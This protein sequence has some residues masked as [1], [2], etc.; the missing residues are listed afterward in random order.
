MSDQLWTLRVVS[1][2]AAKK[3]V[4]PGRRS[5]LLAI[6]W[7][8]LLVPSLTQS[9]DLQGIEGGVPRKL[10][11]WQFPHGEAGFFFFAAGKDT[12]GEQDDVAQYEMIT[13]CV[14]WDEAFELLYQMDD[15]RRPHLIFANGHQ[16]SV[17]HDGENEFPVSIRFVIHQG[18]FKSRVLTPDPQG[19]LAKSD[20]SVRAGDF[21]QIC[22]ADP[23]LEHDQQS[24]VVIQCDQRM[25]YGVSRS[26]VAHDFF[27][28]P[29]MHFVVRGD[30]DLIQLMGGFCTN[31]KSPMQASFVGLAFQIPDGF[32]DRVSRGGLAT[33]RDWDESLR[34]IRQKVLADRKSTPNLTVE[35]EDVI[36]LSQGDFESQAEAFRR[37]VALTQKSNDLVDRHLCSGDAVILDPVARG[38]YLEQLAWDKGTRTSFLLKFSVML[39]AFQERE[40]LFSV[41]ANAASL[42]LGANPLSLGS[43]ELFF[44]GNGRPEIRAA[45]AA[46]WE[47]PTT[48]GEIDSVAQLLASAKLRQTRGD[49]M[50]VLILLGAG[51][52]IPEQQLA[53][54]CQTN[55]IDASTPLRRRKLA[56]LMKTPSGRQLLLRKLAD[57]SLPDAVQALAK[58]I[59]GT[60]VDATKQLKRFDMIGEA[61]LQ[62]LEAAL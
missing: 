53:T 11:K 52:R 2:N 42:G 6:V 14:L 34:Q 45:L 25:L 17:V 27:G 32:L 13:Q 33:A 29:M 35:A 44:D 22:N 50:D 51:D 62:R 19:V 58:S 7:A 59:I 12:A 57:G 18:V 30:D 31:L 1:Q 43:L 9:Q 54:W 15:L 36:R 10:D 3:H 40:M 61:E 28:H 20:F 55:L 5:V 23:R 60:H 26:A 4:L 47:L 24:S 38:F 56:Y 46:H 48:P 21:L 16:H 8:A 49:A 37:C 39:R 41:T